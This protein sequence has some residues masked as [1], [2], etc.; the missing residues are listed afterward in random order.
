M[1]L[2]SAKHSTS[3]S[4]F[5]HETSLRHSASQKGDNLCER[6][7]SELLNLQQHA[8]DTDIDRLQSQL[9]VL[10]ERLNEPECQIPDLSAI[11]AIR[12]EALTLSRDIEDIRCSADADALTTRL[13]K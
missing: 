2:Q 8:D 1:R 9:E 5:S 7:V 4:Q 6:G 11:A 13:Q 3:S 10:N 12:G